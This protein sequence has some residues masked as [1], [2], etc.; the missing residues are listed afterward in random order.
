MGQMRIMVKLNSAESIRGLACLAVVFSHLSLTFFPYLHHFDVEAS[1]GTQLEYLIHHSPFAFW[2][3]G[4]AAV[5]VFF[6]LSGFVLSY[7]ILR[8]P[9]IAQAKIQNMLIKRYPRLAIPAV[10]SCIICWAILQGVNIPSQQ[11]N[12]WFQQYVTQDFSL[13]F[14]LYEGLVGSF[15]F[16]ESSTNWVLW[17]MH[18]ELIGSL[19]LFLL[20]FMYQKSRVLFH[21][22]AVLLPVLA[23]YLKGE[24]FFLGIVSFVVGIY[25]YLY[26]KPLKLWSALL[27]F[28]FGL[29]LAGAHNSSASYQWIFAL[30]GERTYDY[31]NVFAGFIIVYSILMSRDLSAKFDQKFLIWL[32][33]LSFSVYLLHL[34]I[35]YVVGLPVFNYALSMGL[36]YGWSAIFASVIFIVLTL[37]VAEFYSRWIDQF[38]IHSS[39]QF[40]KFVLAL[41]APKHNVLEK[42]SANT[43]NNDSK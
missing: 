42:S 3:S 25:Y 16:A 41:V 36:S 6:V 13:S 39:Q 38:A 32:G 14:A 20:L 29:Y 34:I 27:L 8:K 22:G 35:L 37:F 40:A 21:I 9:E 33:K 26:A 17:T 31:C 28:L 1:A 43:S 24:G 30:L 7:A 2:Y 15:L 10:V 23:W 4:T 12:G 11:V 18:I 5:F 19:V